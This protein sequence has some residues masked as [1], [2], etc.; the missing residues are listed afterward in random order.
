MDGL[1]QVAS[2][3]DHRHTEQNKGMEVGKVAL[4]LGEGYKSQSW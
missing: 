2:E 4:V 3:T 1:A